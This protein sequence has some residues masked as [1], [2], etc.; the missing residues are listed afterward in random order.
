M[1]TSNRV[2]LHKLLSGLIIT[3]GILLVIYMIA[4]EGELGAL[5]L[6]LITFGTGWLLITYFKSQR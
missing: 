6:L 2:K 3:V 4:V 1:D 5:P